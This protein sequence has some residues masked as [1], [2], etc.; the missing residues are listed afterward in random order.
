MLA[1]ETVPGPLPSAHLKK[2]KTTNKQTKHHKKKK[3]NGKN[4][5]YFNNYSI[6]Y[7]FP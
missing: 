7:G 1:R 4:F 6:A 5:V 2:T 3:K